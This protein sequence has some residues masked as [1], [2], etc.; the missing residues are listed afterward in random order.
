MLRRTFKTPLSALAA[1]WLVHTASGVGAAQDADT[2]PAARGEQQDGPR[3]RKHPR[4]PPPEAFSACEGKQEGAECQ[5]SFRERTLEGVC[6]APEKEE[7]FCL[8]ND[9]P[10]PPRR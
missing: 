7:L 4:R 1:I 5:V 2:E 10:P 9:L 3:P 8:P 6:R